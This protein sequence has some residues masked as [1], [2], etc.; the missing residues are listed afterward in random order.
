MNNTGVH[1]R[2][3]RRKSLLSKKSIAAHPQFT[4]DHMDEPVKSP[5]LNE[6][7]EC[8]CMS[9]WVRFNTLNLTLKMKVARKKYG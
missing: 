4:K 8:L 7:T 1:A 2:V 9:S 3:T 6:H 5:V